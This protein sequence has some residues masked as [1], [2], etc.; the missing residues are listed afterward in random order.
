ML[1]R[2]AVRRAHQ[3]RDT[4]AMQRDPVDMRRDDLRRELGMVSTAARLC[5]GAAA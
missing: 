1:D 2:E 5:T 3:P 4:A